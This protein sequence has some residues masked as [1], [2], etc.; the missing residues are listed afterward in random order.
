M[1]LGAILSSDKTNISSMTEKHIV[2]PLLISIANL[3]MNFWMKLSNHAFFL[4]AL[5]P[6]LK[7]IHCNKC[8][9][10]LLKDWLVHKCLNFILQPLNTAAEIG[11]MM[12]DPLGWRCF[13]CTLLTLTPLNL[14]SLLELVGNYLW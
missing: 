6:V 10:G 8:M 14:L 13:C 1:I 12:S 7:F 2:H 5:L 4:L 9:H 11:I 3:N